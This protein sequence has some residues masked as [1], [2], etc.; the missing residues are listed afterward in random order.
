MGG[1]IGCESEFGR[2][3][4]FWI[5]FPIAMTIRSVEETKGPDAPATRAFSDKKAH[6][7]YIED[8]VSNLTLVEHFLREQPQIKLTTAM[9]GTVGVDLA[10]RHR[11]DL[12]LLDVHLP[13]L[14]GAEVL[15]R[16]KSNERTRDIPV[17]VVSADAIER[18]I[19]EFMSNGAAAYMTKP[20][21]VNRFFEV[22]EQHLPVESVPV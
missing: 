12:I 8:N 13:D 9:Q 2:G 21:D 7:L 16:L 14:N 15:A 19:K 20:L 17:V 4:T 22:I 5:E 10:T 11:P 18:R 6:L 3:S 1:T